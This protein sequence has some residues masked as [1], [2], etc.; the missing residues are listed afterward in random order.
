[1]LLLVL[2]CRADA[3][4]AN[5]RFDLAMEEKRL[6]ECEQAKRDAL[7]RNM[8]LRQ[9]G[10]DLVAQMKERLRAKREQTADNYKSER[11]QVCG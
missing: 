1:M 5:A 7:E 2:R 8:Q 9:N 4:I 3:A 11:E 6:A 10:I